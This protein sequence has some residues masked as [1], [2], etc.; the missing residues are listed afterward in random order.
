MSESIE[1]GPEIGTF[2]ELH[3][4]PADAVVIDRAGNR[5]TRDEKGLWANRFG[6]FPTASELRRLLPFRLVRR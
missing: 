1:A 3:A 6:Y 2:D 5:Y 4:L